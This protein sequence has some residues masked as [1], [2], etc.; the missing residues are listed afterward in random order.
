VRVETTF[1][2]FGFVVVNGVVEMSAPIAKWSIGRKGKDVVKYWKSR[3]AQIT[4]RKIET[5][6]AL[7]AH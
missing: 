5:K 7:C 3:G 1:A 4:W 2:V 6:G